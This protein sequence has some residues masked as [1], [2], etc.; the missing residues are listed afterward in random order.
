PY[1]PRSR[2]RRFNGHIR[3]RWPPYANRRS[4]GRGSLGPSYVKSALMAAPAGLDVKQANVVS[5]WPYDRPL[6]ACRFDPAGRFVVCGGE[7]AN[8]ERYNLADGA[9]TKFTG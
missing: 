2:G 7:D 3:H 9:R 5:Q 6:N 4:S 1:V 8:V